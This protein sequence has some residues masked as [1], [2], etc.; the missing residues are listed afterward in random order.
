MDRRDVLHWVS[1]YE[2][3]WRGGDLDAVARL[4]TEGA[5]YWPSP[6]EPPEIGLAAIRK[7]WLDDA[8][9]TFTM[10]SDVEA[11]DGRTAVVRVHVDYGPPN[12]Q[13]YR[14]LWVLRFAEDGRVAHFEEW[15]Y[16]PGKNYS[17]AQ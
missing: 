4:F 1:G 3:A 2:R 8:G 10:S 13:H 12:Q 9:K 16:W 5:R 7:F 17:A 11:V 6:C 14:N 15:P